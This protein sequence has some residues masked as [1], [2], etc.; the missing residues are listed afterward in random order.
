MARWKVSRRTALR[1]AGAAAF[2]AAAGPSVR[3]LS[4][5]AAEDSVAILGILP[6]TG[7]YAADGELIRRGHEMAIEDFGG[8]VGGLR[9]NYVSRDTAGDAGTATRRVSEAIESEDVTAI[10]GP[11]ADDVAAAVSEVAKRHKRVHYWSGGP[12]ECHRYL[13]QWAPPYYTGVRATMDYAVKK[14][15][16]AKRWYRLTSDYA[17]GW[18]LEELEDRLAEE[19]GIEFVGS[20]R[21]VLG[22]REFS[23]FMSDIS[24]ANPDVLVLNNF[25]LDTAQA[26]RSAHSFGLTERAQILVPWGSGIEDYLR[27]EPAI[28]Q[29]I[30]IGS[31]FYYTIDNPQ[32]KDFAE[33]YIDRHGEPPGY[34]AGS[35]YAV[36]RLVLQGIEKARSATPA[37]LVRALE[38]W[39]LDTIVGPTRID[40]ATHQTIRPFFVTEGKGPEEVGGEFDLA[41]IVDVAESDPPADVIECENIGEL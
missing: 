13:F 18:T 29:G 7:P 10:V 37:D 30:I 2:V 39:E 20:A 3:A 8:S 19:R 41:R 12:I 40:A 4:A 25:G 17:F 26:I 35:G 11:W 32:A 5:L 33:R 34:P 1:G 28:T 31:A 15:P 23:R 22:E 21:H 27:L 16:E 6:L 9:I 36:M 24:A 14:K 38:G